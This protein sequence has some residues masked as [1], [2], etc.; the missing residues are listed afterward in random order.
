MPAAWAFSLRF[1]SV[2][3][4]QL[5]LASTKLVRRTLP[6]SVRAPTASFDE[7]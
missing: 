5:A 7:M 6:T 1:A 4:V 2:D 3:A